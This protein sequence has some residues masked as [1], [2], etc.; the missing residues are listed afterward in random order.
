VSRLEKRTFWS[1]MGVA[2]VLHMYLV[3]DSMGLLTI[4]LWVN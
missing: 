1:F 3:I 4:S 2:F